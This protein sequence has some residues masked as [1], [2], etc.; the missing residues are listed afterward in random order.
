MSIDRAEPPHSGPEREVLQGFLDYQR[1]TM[2]RKILGLDRTQAL[3]RLVPSDATLLGMLKHLAYVER[4]WFRGVLAG[5]DIAFPWSDDDPDA[6]WRIEPGETVES[7]IGL[8]RE[9]C[10]AADRTAAHYALQDVS[11]GRGRDVSLRW[12]LTHMIEETAR[13]CGQADILRELTD[14]ATGE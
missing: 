13:H 7:I 9:E 2:V 11:S 10:A 12:I 6:D 8:Y 1:G 14:G 4:Y 3:R 5:E